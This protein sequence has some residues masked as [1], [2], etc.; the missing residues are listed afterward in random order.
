M[1]RS[2]GCP[3]KSV[4]VPVSCG[5]SDSSAAGGF[6]ILADTAT[7]RMDSH[8]DRRRLLVPLSRFISSL[9]ARRQSQH[10]ITM[11]VDILRCTVHDDRCTQLTG[12][13]HIRGRERT[14]NDERHVRS[15]IV[16]RVERCRR[17][18]AV[19]STWFRQGRIV[20]CL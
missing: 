11:A 18:R 9:R 20:S 2:P 5:R 14:V 4:Q 17:L 13:D 16:P 3:L 8:S 1:R 7:I 15:R 19:D 12:S 6:S 10:H